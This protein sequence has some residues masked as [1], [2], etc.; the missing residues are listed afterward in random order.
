MRTADAFV[1]LCTG[2]FAPFRSRRPVLLPDRVLA[3]TVQAVF[4]GGRLGVIVPI[5][6]QGAGAVRRWAAVDP[7]VVV[8]VASPLRAG[9]SS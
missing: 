9:L 2:A 3:A 7:A 6:Q 8:A 5:P 4:E 1:I